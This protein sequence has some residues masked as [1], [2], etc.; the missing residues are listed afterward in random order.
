MSERSSPEEIGEDKEESEE[1]SGLL[2]QYLQE[3]HREFDTVIRDI[4]TPS[5]TQLPRVSKVP[6]S[7]TGFQLDQ[8]SISWSKEAADKS[9]LEVPRFEESQEKTSAEN[10]FSD[11]FISDPSQSLIKTR[12]NQSKMSPSYANTGCFDLVSACTEEQMEQD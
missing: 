1:L 7:P 4:T 12:V 5:P 2:D 9:K 8:E 3:L 10:C 6:V 11:P